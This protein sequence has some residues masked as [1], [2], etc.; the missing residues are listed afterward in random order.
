[1]KQILMIFGLFL[2]TNSYGQNFDFELVLRP[3]ISDKII[4]DKDKD[5]GSSIASIIKPGLTLDFGA[6]VNKHLGDKGKLGVGLLFS[7]YGHSYKIDSYELSYKSRYKLNFIC[8]PLTYS[9][10][11][12][13]SM[14]VNLGI[15]NN[16]LLRSKEILKYNTEGIDDTTVVKKMNELKELKYNIFNPSLEIAF[17]WIIKVSDGF[18]FI[19]QPNFSVLLFN[20]QKGNDIHSSYYKVGLNIKL[21][22]N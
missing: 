8:I 9:R 20:I 21:M 7:N 11:M 10:R 4:Y 1:M 2:I 17:G 12:K 15:G 22:N 6:V 13:K 3:S 18:S 5:I 19:L 16:I 14:I